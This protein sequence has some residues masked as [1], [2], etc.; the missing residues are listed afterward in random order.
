MMEEAW[1][2]YGYW[3]QST[4]ASAKEEAASIVE[5]LQRSDAQS[6]EAIALD[7]LL[8]LVEHLESELETYRYELNTR[9]S[10]D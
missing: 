8:A 6:S 9:P 4:V 3:T 5:R 1:W 7:R 10:K 2:K